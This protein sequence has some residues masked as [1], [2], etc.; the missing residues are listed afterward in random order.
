MIYLIGYILILIFYIFM[1]RESIK[2]TTDLVRRNEASA[3]HR[4]IKLENYIKDLENY[5]DVYH[6]EDTK[7]G[8]KKREIK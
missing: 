1:L 6:Y 7:S 2:S 3:L 4:F 8:Y 5:L